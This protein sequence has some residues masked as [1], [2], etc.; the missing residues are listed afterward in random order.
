MAKFNTGLKNMFT[1]NIGIKILSFLAAFVVW[2]LVIT[3]NDPVQTKIFHVKVQ[4]VHEDALTSVNKVFEIV[5]NQEVS[6]SVTGKRSAV[7]EIEEKDIKAVADLAKLSSV[8]SVSVNASIKKKTTSKVRVECDDVLQLALEDRATK[9][10]Q[11][12]IET[13]GMPQEGYSIGES[14]AKPN[15][16]Q[17]TCGVSTM[18]RIENVKV[19]VDVDGASENISRNEKVQAYDGAGKKVTSNT[20]QFSD[21]NVLTKI[22]ILENKTIPVELNV[23]GE[24]AAGYE[25]VSVD[26]V[27]EDIAITGSKKKLKDLDKLVVPIDVN[28]MKPSSRDVEQTLDVNKMLPLEV[29]PAEGSENLSVKIVIEKI[30]EETIDLTGRDITFKNVPSKLEGSIDREGQ[31]YSVT[32]SGIASKMRKVSKDDLKPYLDCTDMD[33]GPHALSVKVDLPEGVRIIDSTLLDVRFTKK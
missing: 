14:I 28:G 2:L 19:V 21:V 33:A 20:L 31:S 30:E 3:I 32:I 29:N 6:V 10:F 12:I 11:V 24:P 9:Q 25:L 1:Q 13:S 27:P 15:M 4:T 23:V 18:S 17:V 7:G 16:V 26:C 22:K 5:S 8:N